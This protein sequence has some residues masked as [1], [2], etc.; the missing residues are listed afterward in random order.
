MS[1]RVWKRVGAWVAVA[2][3]AAVTFALGGALGIGAVWAVWTA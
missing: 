1:R 2:L 3:G